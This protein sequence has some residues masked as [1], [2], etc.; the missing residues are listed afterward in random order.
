MWDTFDL[1][2]G[3]E[4]AYSACI[5]SD[6]YGHLLAGDIELVYNVCDTAEAS[7]DYLYSQKLMTV[8]YT[9]E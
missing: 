2:N 6:A 5:V 8:T 9:A 4:R 7:A 3:Y 1:D